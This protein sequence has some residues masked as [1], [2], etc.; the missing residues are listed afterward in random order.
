MKH[1]TLK[2]DDLARVIATGQVGIVVAASYGATSSRYT[3]R[4]SKGEKV[5][6]NHDQVLP[7]YPGN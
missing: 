3:L 5:S 2:L 6:V 1:D 7:A 4:L